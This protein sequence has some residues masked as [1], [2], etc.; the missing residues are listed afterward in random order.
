MFNSVGMGEFLVLMVLILVVM[1]PEKFPEV[2]KIAL[3]FFRD[4]RG[5]VDDLRREISQEMRPV[6]RELADL[7]RLDPESYIDAIAKAADAVSDDENEDE[8]EEDLN[9]AE[10]QAEEDKTSDGASSPVADPS[11]TEPAFTDYED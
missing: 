11:S 8:E 4:F 7:S 10:V 6:K 1:G 9:E 5:Y 2:A 3:R